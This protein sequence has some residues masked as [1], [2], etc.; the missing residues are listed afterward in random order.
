MVTRPFTF[1]RSRL[2]ANYSTS[3]AGGV[4]VEIQ[5][6]AGQPIPGYAL[7]DADPLVGDEI[8]RVVTWGGQ[9]DVGP[10]AGKPMRLRFVMRD[11]DL[12]SLQF[13]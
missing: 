9:N 8:L 4:Q 13:E 10:L 12:Y 11:A 7:A 3:A 5:D 2:A 6:A 1:D